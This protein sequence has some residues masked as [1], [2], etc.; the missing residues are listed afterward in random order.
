MNRVLDQCYRC[1]GYV[2]HPFLFLR[3]AVDLAFLFIFRHNYTYVI[4]YPEVDTG[5]RT[6][7]LTRQKAEKSLN[8]FCRG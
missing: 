8:L 1:A 3:E 2:K 6:V 5:V 4:W 7:S